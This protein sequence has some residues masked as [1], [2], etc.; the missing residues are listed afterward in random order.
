MADLRHG[1]FIC[2]IYPDLGRLGW[3]RFDWRRVSLSLKHIFVER[4]WAIRQ[5]N[6]SFR[7]S[8]ENLQN[9]KKLHSRKQAI[10]R[11]CGLVWE[12]GYDCIACVILFLQYGTYVSVLPDT[13]VELNTDVVSGILT[14]NCCATVKTSVDKP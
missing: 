3:V 8:N 9:H 11:E 1:H 14:K 13:E 7:F 12:R 10:F 5:N 4:Y 6:D 2:L